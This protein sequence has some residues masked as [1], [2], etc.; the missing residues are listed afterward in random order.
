MGNIFISYRFTGENPAK[1]EYILG[2]MRKS[3]QSAGH[4]VICSFYYEDFFKK[5]CFTASQI[6]HYMLER[7]GESDVFMALVKTLDRSNGM[8]MESEKAIKLNQR[9]VLAIK[10]GLY[11]RELNEAADEIINYED[12]EGLF[13]A[14]NNFR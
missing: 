4:S 10:K 13:R 14:L 5:N 7:Q 8:L 11:I 6:Y 3:L 1:L 2:G 9:Y 12:F